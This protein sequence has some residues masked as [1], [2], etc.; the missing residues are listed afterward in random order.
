MSLEEMAGNIAPIDETQSA[1]S[2]EVSV[3]PTG[4]VLEQPQ[5][6]DEE[7]KAMEQG[8]RPKE[9]YSGPEDD[10]VDAHTYLGRGT[11]LK[12]IKS[13]KH[14]LDEQ[15]KTTEMVMEHTKYMEKLMYEK[16][17]KEIEAEQK[18]ARMRG[19]FE[20]YDRATQEL[21]DLKPISEQPKNPLDHP[22]VQRFLNSNPWFNN[23][24]TANEFEL[25]AIAK[26]A[27]A[28][29]AKAN[30]NAAIDEVVAYVEKRV[31][32][33]RKDYMTNNNRETPSPTA[34]SSAIRT[35][36]T[37]KPTAKAPHPE[38]NKL[39]DFQKQVVKQM[40]DPKYGVKGYKENPAEGI[41]KYIEELKQLNAI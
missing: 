19:D 21:Q 15:R 10:W 12:Q 27:D 4:E 30:P 24:Q 11:F 18:A 31:Q 36:G 41:N 37:G 22:E 16:A 28:Y 29:Y 26:A 32:E 33:K 40:T 20:A 23:P 39:S 13:L 8:W 35:Q 6:S 25:Q 3:E 17:R 9:E 7:V 5:Y 2:A 38:W 34:V 1:P 14:D